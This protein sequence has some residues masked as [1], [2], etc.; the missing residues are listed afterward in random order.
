MN[1]DNHDFGVAVEAE[2]LKDVASVVRSAWGRS[3]VLLLFAFALVAMAACGE[4]R[5]GYRTANTY[6]GCIA[7]CDEANECGGMGSDCSLSCSFYMLES[8]GWYQFTKAEKE[9]FKGMSEYFACVSSTCTLDE[10]GEAYYSQ[11]AI[12]EC[13]PIADKYDAVCEQADRDRD[14][15]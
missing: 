6:E 4:K 15:E 7:Q 2:N 3:L 1:R 12:E 14:Y 5:R 11:E 8:L 9:C 13:E 10:N